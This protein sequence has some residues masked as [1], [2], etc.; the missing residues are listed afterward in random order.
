MG[1]IPIPTRDGLH[2]HGSPSAW[3]KST[4]R[5]HDKQ[6]GGIPG[7]SWLSFSLCMHIRF[8]KHQQ[9]LLHACAGEQERPSWSLDV[10]DVHSFQAVAVGSQKRSVIS[11]KLNFF[12]PN[13]LRAQI[14]PEKSS[15]WT[16]E[17]SRGSERRRK[18][19]TEVSPIQCLLERVKPPPH[20]PVF[21]PQEHRN[22]IT[23]PSLAST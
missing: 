2:C 21:P 1:I 18:A 11:L 9:A 8:P 10:V 16:L 19:R 6:V 22:P 23:P 17:I 20:T 4:C 7:H 3:R 12:F 13:S 14:I 15:L 5:W